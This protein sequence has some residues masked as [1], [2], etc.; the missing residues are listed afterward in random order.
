MKRCERCQTINPGSA[1]YC[2]QCGLMLPLREEPQEPEVQ[3]KPNYNTFLLSVLGSL[4]LSLILVYVFKLPIFFLAGF[5]P[6][7]WPRKKS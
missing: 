4:A 6:L 7:L 5:L 3:A 1:R 2:M